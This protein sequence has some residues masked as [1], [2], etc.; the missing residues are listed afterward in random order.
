M[1]NTVEKRKFRYWSED[2]L[3][4]D[5]GGVLSSLLSGKYRCNWTGKEDGVNWGREGGGEER[6]VGKEEGEGSA[7]VGWAVDTRRVLSRWWW[8]VVCCRIVSTRVGRVATTTSSLRIASC[9]WRGA[10]VWTR[11]HPR[12]RAS[13]T[14]SKH[15]RSHIDHII[16]VLTL[17]NAPSLKTPGL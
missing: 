11:R 3:S 8:V 17:V 10:C 7:P 1:K 9:W 5:W 14:G 13:A 15:L 2:F 6:E 16:T 12:P 4:N